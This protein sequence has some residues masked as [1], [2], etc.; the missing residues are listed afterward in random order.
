M[1]ASR[2]TSA[3]Q[4]IKGARKRGWR[5]RRRSRSHSISR[6][7]YL[8]RAPRRRRCRPR[9]P[10]GRAGPG[11]RSAAPAGRDLVAETAGP[12]SAPNTALIAA[13][14]LASPAG[15]EVAWAFRCP[16]LA[17]AMRR[18]HVISLGA[19]AIAEQFG[20]RHGTAPQGMPEFFD[21]QDARPL[22]HDEAVP[23]Q[24]E[25][26]RGR[27]GIVVEAGRHRPGGGEGSQADAVDA[28]LGPAADGD[29]GLAGPD[30]A[31]GV[32]DGLG[33]GGAGGDGRAPT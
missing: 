13:S 22:A 14:S 10:P 16:M 3:P 12:R 1:L 26:P 18:G 19:G 4:R 5:S 8:S 7:P 29:I 11:S 21:D 20:D 30:Q 15:V 17:G 31:R 28:G 32:A 24:V 33:A 23:L 27:R 9:P 25:G 6:T 2:T